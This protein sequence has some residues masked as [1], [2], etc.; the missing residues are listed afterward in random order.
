MRFCISVI[1]LFNFFQVIERGNDSEF[2]LAAAVYTKDIENA[3]YLAK[4]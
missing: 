1:Q 4:V 2:G 3:F